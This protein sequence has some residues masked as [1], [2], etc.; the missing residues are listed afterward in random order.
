M[1]LTIKTIALL[2]FAVGLVQLQAFSLNM[3]TPVSRK[4]STK[5]A[6]TRSND[7]SSTI[8][9]DPPPKV[10]TT[11]RKKK[12][13]EDRI[14]TIAFLNDPSRRY[15]KRRRPRALS[16]FDRERRAMAKAATKAQ[17]M[18]K[19]QEG[20]RAAEKAILSVLKE[21]NIQDDCI[22]PWS[23]VNKADFLGRQ[24]E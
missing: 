17:V 21:H 16:D 10:T 8:T 1:T 3:A 2:F 7:A 4:S 22:A 23:T 6:Y 5:L 9:M 14:E 19:F 24:E 15:Q 18:A 11:R 13:A 20:Q 12:Q